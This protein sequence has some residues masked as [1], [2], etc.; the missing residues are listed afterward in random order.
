MSA[1]TLTAFDDARPFAEQ[2][3]LFVADEDGCGGRGTSKA[4]VFPRVGVCV[5]VQAGRACVS[6]RLCMLACPASLRAGLRAYELRRTSWSPLWA[7]QDAAGHVDASVRGAETYEVVLFRPD[8]GPGMSLA[9]S[10]V[11]VDA[12]AKSVPHAAVEALLARISKSERELAEQS[13]RD[14]EWVV[15]D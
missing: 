13:A 15:V 3:E 5:S 4:F 7:G 12:C 8:S 1:D 9:P 2:L 10:D 14:A 6:R 11:E